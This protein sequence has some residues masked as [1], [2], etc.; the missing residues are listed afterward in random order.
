MLEKIDRSYQSDEQSMHREGSSADEAVHLD[1]EF[2]HR[3]L[4]TRLGILVLGF[5]SGRGRKNVTQS[6]LIQRIQRR[7]SR[8]APG[9]IDF[10]RRPAS[11]KLFRYMSDLRAALNVFRRPLIRCLEEGAGPERA[12]ANYSG[13]GALEIKSRLR[14]GYRR[15][16]E[17]YRTQTAEVYAGTHR[18]AGPA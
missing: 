16:N 6:C 8:R 4:I 14:S 7:V 11:A 18:Y 5:L 2:K 17:R 10:R 1:E 9:L 12:A 13:A 15:H 3:S